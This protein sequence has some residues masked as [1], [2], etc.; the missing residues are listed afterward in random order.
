MSQ[1]ISAGLILRLQALRH[2]ENTKEAIEFVQETLTQLDRV[3]AADQKVST[4]MIQRLLGNRPDLVLAAMKLKAKPVNL[5]SMLDGE[6]ITTGDATL[7]MSMVMDSLV[8]H[9]QAVASGASNQAPLTGELRAMTQAYKERSETNEM[10]DQRSNMNEM[11]VRRPVHTPDA[12]YPES[13]K[14]LPPHMNTEAIMDD[15]EKTRIAPI[16]YEEE[17][18]AV[19]CHVWTDKDITV[20]VNNPSLPFFLG[21]PHSFVW[22]HPGPIEGKQKLYLRNCIDDMPEQ[23]SSGIAKMCSMVVW[24]NTQW[25][26]ALGDIPEGKMLS[27]EI[28]VES[29]YYNCGQHVLLIAAT[30]DKIERSYFPTMRHAIPYM[31]EMKSKNSKM[32][33]KAY[34]V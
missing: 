25:E 22:T 30:P 23:F 10:K 17:D 32:L 29:Q 28:N 4:E 6:E 26:K 12:Q 15:D 13:P 19:Y 9:E 34:Y 24:N 16:L 18:D 33:I 7:P 14:H 11:K 1:F 21:A 31:K 3:D 2:A 20:T 27:D 5:N 8:R